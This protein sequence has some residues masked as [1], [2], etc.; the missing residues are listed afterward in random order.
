ME[1]IMAQTHARRSFAGCLLAALVFLSVSTRAEDEAASGATGTPQAP[2]SGNPWAVPEEASCNPKGGP[3]GLAVR[4]DVAGVP[5]QPGDV[6]AMDRLQILKDYLPEFLWQERERFFYEGMH[7]EIGPCFRD[8]SAPAFFQQATEQ[9]AGEASIDENRGLVGYSAG[10]PFAPEGI[11]VDD[12]QAGL[13]WFWN[14][15]LR[16]QGAGF[17]GKFRLTDLLGRVGRAEAFTGEMFKL[18]LTYR[19]DRPE[20]NYT[21][22]NANQNHWVAGGLFFEPFNARENAWRQY[23]NVE[24]MTVERRSDDLKAYLPQWRRVRRINSNQ[25]EGLYMPSFS[26]GVVPN[27]Q[28]A[29]G[30]GSADAGGIGGGIGAGGVGGTI[31]T[32]RS[33]YEGLE[34]RPNLYEARV[35]GL[36]DVLAPINI[37]GAVYPEAEDRSFGPW[38]LSFASDRWGFRRA[39]V[40]DATLDADIG[41]DDVSR[42]LLYVDL[43]TLQPLYMATFD[44]K[45]EMSN[46]GVYAGRWS[47]DREGYP[48]WP[49][50]E[51]RSVRVIDSVGAAFANLSMDGSWRRESWENVSTPP[52]DRTVKRMISEGELTKRR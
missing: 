16:Y 19:A 30:G 48:P 34:F 29:V 8:Y 39:L 24:N 6:F 33:G 40:I 38:G 21:T 46:V 3:L 50:D 1:G 11:A 20:S 51:D 13:K 7:L 18:I 49:D 14:V 25:V 47:E 10:L 45:G 9:H 2:A 15:Q 42:T 35:A 5:F 44:G 28:L 37:A 26:V 22:P 23:R 4:E 41:S 52:D 43:Q 32:K 17:R 27:Q 36:H 12:P 31:Q